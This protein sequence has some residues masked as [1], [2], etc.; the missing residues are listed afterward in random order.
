[1]SLGDFSD[2]RGARTAASRNLRRLAKFLHVS[3]GEM[4]IPEFDRGLISKI[5]PTK[6]KPSL[7]EIIKRAWE[8][9]Q[10]FDLS[11]VGYG[12]AH[13]KAE[14]KLHETPFP[15]YYFLAG[16]VRSQN[17]KRIFEI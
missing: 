3:A 13:W 15:Y 16:L 17:C 7:I 1:M 6:P 9:G 12:P 4:A 10:T 14:K 8:V 2:R 11:D 5:S